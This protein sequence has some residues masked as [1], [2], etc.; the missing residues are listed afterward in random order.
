VE[1]RPDGSR[2]QIVPDP[3]VT[4]MTDK[5][6]ALRSM[7]EKGTGADPLREMIGFTAERLMEVEERHALLKGLHQLGRRRPAFRLVR[8][9]ATMDNRRRIGRPSEKFSLS[10]VDYWGRGSS[11][12]INRVPA[13]RGR[14][15]GRCRTAPL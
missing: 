15:V 6:V 3:G 8:N 10:H 1:F 7:L 11:A 4:A 14:A 5:M 12:S 13:L 2:G 9:P